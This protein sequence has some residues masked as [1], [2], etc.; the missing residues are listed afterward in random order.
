M[1]EQKAIPFKLVAEN[2]IVK[3]LYIERTIVTLTAELLY[4][5]PPVGIPKSREAVFDYSRMV[6]P[7]L[8]HKIAV[9]VCVL[10]VNMIHTASIL[11]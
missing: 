10:G 6:Y 3:T 9:N 4:A 7:V 2:G 8:V 1:R 11:L 5:E